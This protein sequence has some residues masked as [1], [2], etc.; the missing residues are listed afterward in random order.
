M[1][2]CENLQVLKEY[3][4]ILPEIKEYDDLIDD[5][6]YKYERLWIF[7][8]KIWNEEIAEFDVTLCKS[9]GMIFTNPR[10]TAEEIRIKYKTVSELESAKKRTQKQ[11]ALKT[12]ERANRIYSLIAGLQE[13]A[14]KSRKIIDYGGHKVTISALLLKRVILVIFL[15]M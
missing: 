5:V 13:N 2:E 7:F 6:T 8:E 9:C 1:C 10:F 11:P 12:D 15:T 4:F 3:Q 14:S